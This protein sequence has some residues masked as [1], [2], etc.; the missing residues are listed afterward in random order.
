MP[1][2]QAS[3]CGDPPPAALVRA[4]LGALPDLAGE[5]WQPLA[6]GRSNRVWRLGSVVV[7]LYDRAAASPLF[8]NDAC[9]EAGALVRLGPHGLAPRL[10]AAGEGWVCYT[11]VAGRPWS[12]DPAPVAAL[13]AKVHAFSGSGFRQVGSGHAALVGQGRAMLAACQGALPPP[14]AGDVPPVVR[15]CLIHGDVVAGNVIA[16]PQGVMLIDWQC[17]AEGDAAEDL[18]AFL[19]PAMQ[20][21]YRGR[22]LDSGQQAAF[23]A[24]CPPLLAARYRALAPAFHWRMAAH[25]LWKAERGAVDYAAAIALELAAL[26]RSVEANAHEISQI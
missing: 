11:H 12:G 1:L 14:P 22:V 26:A 18:A 9:A 16:G 15:P 5:N 3:I 24:A 13:L 25:C 10:C 21:L 2:T 17:P 8:P 4:V 20:M 19:S 7:K 23:L 6:G